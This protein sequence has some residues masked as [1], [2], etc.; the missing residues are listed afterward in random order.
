MTSA[1]GPVAAPATVGWS[2]RAGV[3]R[4]RAPLVAGG[5]T[6]AATVVVALHSPY[7]AGS[8]GYCWFHALTGLWC[9]LCG[10]MRAT[11]DLAHGR[12]SAAWGMNPLWVAAVPFVIAAWALW[13]ARS[14]RGARPLPVPKRAWWALAAVV[15]AFGVLRN[16]PAFAPW[17]AP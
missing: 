15:L 8:Y 6:A 3:A 4:V 10:G 13:G 7:V 5:V 12:V 17:L 16:V 1:D 2:G 9:P 14:A 11:Y